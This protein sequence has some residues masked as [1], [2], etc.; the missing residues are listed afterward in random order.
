MFGSVAHTELALLGSVAMLEE[1]WHCGV[2]DADA[3]A[4]CLTGSLVNSWPCLLS[5][6]VVY[7]TTKSNLEE[8]GLIWLEQCGHKLS[9]R[10]F[11]AG[12]QGK[13]LETGNS[14]RQLR[15]R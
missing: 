9:L 13:N 3:S 15:E 4:A 2:G 7:T 12:T 5:T 6:A 10:D 14:D 8:K 1:M 11:R